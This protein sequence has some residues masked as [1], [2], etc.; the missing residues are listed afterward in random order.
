MFDVYGRFRL[1][2][3]RADDGWWAVFAVGE[4]GKRTWIDHVV[5]PSGA[6][7]DE[8]EAAI[9]ASYHELARPGTDIVRLDEPS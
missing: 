3:E 4:D 2:A 6:G 9:E 8:V 5:V 7:V 1:A